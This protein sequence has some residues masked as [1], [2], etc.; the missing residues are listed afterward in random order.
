[1]LIEF[2]VE[3]WRSFR[4]RTT[5]SM[6]ATREKQHRERIARIGKIARILPITAIYG[7]NASGKT[8][9]FHALAFMR[10]T[11]VDGIRLNRK[12]TVERFKLDSRYEQKPTTFEIVILKDKK[13]YRYGFSIAY[14][15][16]K[17]ENTITGEHLEVTGSNGKEKELFDRDRKFINTDREFVK[18]I[19]NKHTRDNQLFLTTSIEMN[20]DDFSAVYKWFNECLTLIA[21]DSR[22]EPFEAFFTPNSPISDEMNCALQNLDTGIVELG[23]KD[24][25]IENLEIPA[26][27]KQDIT[28]K[29][30]GSTLARIMVN[31]QRYLIR[32]INGVLSAK[33]LIA[34]HLTKD[35]KRVSF[36]ISQESDGTQRVIELFPAFI[37][38]VKNDNEKVFVIDELDR[39]LHTLLTRY[40]IRHFLNNCDS[41]KRTQM[42]V[43]LHDIVLMDQDLFRRDEILLTERDNDGC[44]KL[45]SLSEY[46]LRYDKVVSRNYLLGKL[47]GVPLI[48]G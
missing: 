11:V 41:N 6:I 25:P 9:L 31:N 13:I 18:E 1:M 28:E 29:V 22:F 37:D 30:H 16:E 32:N 40:M 44:S 2:T 48:W 38:A 17:K 8:N 23:S 42:I 14:N 33:M 21:P 36:D 24:I 39:S 46:V 47:G 5:F 43:T 10:K 7:G 20:I 35:N 15:K 34:Q 19:F 45:I 27:L 4:D 26:Y 3:N 12:I